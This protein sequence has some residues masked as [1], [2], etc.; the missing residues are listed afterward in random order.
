MI[1]PMALMA[2]PSKYREHDSY[3]EADLKMKRRG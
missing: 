1:S 2:R 3:V